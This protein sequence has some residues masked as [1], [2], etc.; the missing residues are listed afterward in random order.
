MMRMVL[1][2]LIARNTTRL[3]LRSMTFWICFVVIIVGVVFLQIMELS[4]FSD[5][6]TL[7]EVTLASFFPYMYAVL[8]S[9]L[10]VL[11][12]IFLVKPLRG[13]DERVDSVEVIYARSESNIEYV[14]GVAWGFVRVFLAMGVVSMIF[15]YCFI[16]LP[17]STPPS[18]W[19]YTYFIF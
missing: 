11:P 14:W 12:L 17:V 2:D 3:L 13:G 18:I 7:G 1:L 19:V 4:S 15:P 8:F 16:C 10:Q 6:P 9:V 5:S